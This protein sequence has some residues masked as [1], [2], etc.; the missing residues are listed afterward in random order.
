MPEAV[1]GVIS[2]GQPDPHLSHP[3]PPYKAEPLRYIREPLLVLRERIANLCL[4]FINPVGAVCLDHYTHSQKITVPAPNLQKL[5][6]P[7][8]FAIHWH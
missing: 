3:L 6:V 2:A 7:L 5:T 1:K 4:Q 8:D